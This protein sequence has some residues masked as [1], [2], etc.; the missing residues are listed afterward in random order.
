MTRAALAKIHIAKKELALDD[1]TYRAV[2]KRVTGETSSAKLNDG[3]RE[4]VLAEFR[5]LGWQPKKPFRKPSTNPHIRK[6][7]ALGKELD[8]RGYWNLPWKRGLIAF[9]KKET[10]IDDPDWLDTRQASQVIEA[11]KAI[12]ARLARKEA[13]T[14]NKNQVK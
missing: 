5:R 12:V 7:W 3:E 13:R 9:V 1:D 6:L 4:K 2:L 8:R 10:G 11:L 14:D